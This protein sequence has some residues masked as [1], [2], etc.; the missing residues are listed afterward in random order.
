MAR[1]A[2][3]ARERSPT[4]TPIELCTTVNH[5]PAFE[6]RVPSGIPELDHLAGGGFP[7]HRAVLVCGDIGTGKTI[8]GLQFLMAGEARGEA[9]VMVSVDQKPQHVIED[10]RRFGWDIAAAVAQR[11]LVVLDASPLFMA[12]RA[13]QSL[14]AR[15]VASDLAQQVRQ[16][17]ATR[18]VIDGATSLAPAGDADE[19]VRSLIFS[20]EDNLGCTTLLTARTVGGAHD[21]A[22]GTSAERLA[23]GVIELRLTPRCDAE[24]VPAQSRRSLFIR[25]MRGA[26]CAID[27]QPL[28]IVDG[29]GL[30]L[31]EAPA[32]Y[33]SPLP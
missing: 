14:D 10:A 1:G 2:A 25:K 6:P 16:A 24:D 32:D 29:R 9:G 3:A 5:E 28:D 33:S 20:L 13:K 15:H 27:E 26:P 22:I 11:R 7:R 17:S 21:S 23:S 31:R 12:L 8:F 30:V 4:G 18:L 19:F